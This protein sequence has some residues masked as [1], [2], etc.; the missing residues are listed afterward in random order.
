MDYTILTYTL[1]AVAC[2]SLI[3][4]IGVISLS[5]RANN[6]LKITNFLVSLSAGTLLGGAFLHLLP[7]TLEN[8]VYGFKVWY[9]VL[10]GIIGFYILEKLI[11]WRHCHVPTASDH[12]HNI[13]RMNLLGDGLHNLLDGTIIAGAFLTN[14]ELGIATTIAVIAHEIPQEIADFGVLLYAGYGRAKAILFNFLISLFSFLGALLVFSLGS[15][16]TQI[17]DIIVPI[18][19]GGFIYIATADMMPELLKEPMIKKSFVQLLFILAGIG[20]MV[21]LLH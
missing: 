16:I 12:P 4:F 19:A 18:T 9:F 5:I 10:A 15:Y 17:T 20:L 21:L 8:N 11:C 3:S 2:V 7:E 6:L 13:G 1:L 14:T